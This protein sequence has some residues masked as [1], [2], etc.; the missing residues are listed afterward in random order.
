MILSLHRI[1]QKKHAKIVNK[2]AEVFRM[3]KSMKHLPQKSQRR[4]HLI[5]DLI[6][7]YVKGHCMIILYGSYARGNY[8]TLDVST[9]EWGQ[10]RIFQSDFDILI[11]IPNNAHSV[12]ERQLEKVEREYEKALGI[13]IHTPLDMIV[14]SI[15][16]VNK[17]L[18]RKQ[19]FFTDIIRE[20]ILLY[21]DGS[22]KLSKPKSLD[23]A[24]IKA[25][26]EEYFGRFY[27]YGSDFLKAARYDWNDGTYVHGVFEL[28]QA[29]ENFYKVLL[30]VNTNYAPPYHKLDR[31][32]K[33]AK[34]Y[35]PE[36]FELFNLYNS[37]ERECF[38]LLCEAYVSGRYSP[39]YVITKE[40]FECLLNKTER[41]AEIVKKSCTEKILSYS[42]E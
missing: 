36:L 21:D 25:I 11:I 26:A 6:N 17:K 31:L 29:C 24:E 19:Y 9:E 22:C 8:V 4:I 2:I 23:Y 30:L 14:E 5:V 12:V 20:G 34:R 10:E 40:Q 42:E 16:D 15:D 38:H 32:R 7:K 3:K 41:F 28:H 35:C 37:F 39:N 18:E 1:W 33:S 27:G 13:T